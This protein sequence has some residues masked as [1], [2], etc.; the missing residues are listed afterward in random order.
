MRKMWLA[1]AWVVAGFGIAVGVR[2]ADMPEF[3]IVLQNH[4]FQPATLKVPAN[5][6]FKVLVTN[7]NPVPSEFES[8]DFNREKIVL[9][10]TTVT[11]FIGPLDKGSYRFFDDF[12]Q[13]TTGTLVAE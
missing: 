9:P 2:A 1:I 3:R 8:G 7:R 4:Q 6:R 13:A 11:V 10:N 12:H 5:T